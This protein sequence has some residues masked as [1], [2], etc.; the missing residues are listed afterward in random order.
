MVIRMEHIEIEYKILL[1]K[2]IFHQI[3]KDYHSRIKEDYIQINDYFT[4]PLLQQKKYML[5]VRSKNNQYE[6]TLK[7]PINDHRI[8]TNILLS[9]QDKE[10]FYQNHELHNEIVDILKKEGIDLKDLKQQFSLTTHRYDIEFEEGIL[11]LDENT[12]LQQKDYELEFEVY[13]EDT[14]YIKFLEI[15]KPYHLQYIKN[16]DSKIKRVLD[17][18]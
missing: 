10:H 6:M 15:I 13:H 2:D 16:C 18:I 5:R 1:T 4:H 9:V 3:L 7:R 11:S 17:A 8:E 14:G 12:Y